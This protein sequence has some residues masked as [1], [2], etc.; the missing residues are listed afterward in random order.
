[1]SITNQFEIIPLND[2]INLLI[3]KDKD[4]KYITFKRFISCEVK[5]NLPGVYTFK[6]KVI[7]DKDNEE[8]FELPSVYQQYFEDV[9]DKIIKQLKD[10]S[11]RKKDRDEADF[12]NTIGNFFF[13]SLIFGSIFIIGSAFGKKSN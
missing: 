7:N 13:G 6:I 1:M 8:T 12:C 3:I 10:I 2:N 11:M 4:V 9:N 5:Q